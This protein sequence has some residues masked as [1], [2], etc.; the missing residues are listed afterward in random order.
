MGVPPHLHHPAA[1][2][3]AGHV[4][5]CVVHGSGSGEPRYAIS[6]QHH[7]LESVARQQLYAQSA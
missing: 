3:A 2:V 7:P 5:H 4:G 1:D 6:E